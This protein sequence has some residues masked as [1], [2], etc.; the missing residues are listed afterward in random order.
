MNILY[1]N[2]ELATNDGSNYHALGILNNLQKQLGTDCVRCYPDPL[3][4]SKQ[5]VNHSSIKRREKYKLALQL[6]RIIRKTILSYT[7]YR[8]ICQKL[9]AENWKPTHVLARSVI[10]DTTAIRVA[11]YFRAK[12]IFEVNAPLYYEQCIINKLPL[13]HA[14]KHWEHTILKKADLIY[15]VSDICR[16]MLLE[17]YPDVK[18]DFVVIPNGYMDELYSM[19][20]TKKNKIRNTIR[21]KENLDSKFVITFIGSLKKW[22]GISFLCELASY[23]ESNPAYHFLVIGDG[24]ER[25]TVVEH[26]KKHNNMTY[27]GKLDSIQM[28][29]Y[30]LA[31]DLGIM[32]YEKNNKFYFSPLKMYDMIGS[33]LP[34]IGTD[35][36]Q[37]HDIAVTYLN[38][39]FLIENFSITNIYNQIIDISTDNTKYQ[40]MQTLLT[41][42]CK[43]SSWNYRAIQL[44]SAL[45]QLS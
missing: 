4:G 19:P 40:N 20:N 43:K 24:S 17:Q 23:F 13:A 27:V 11:R 10:F 32:P 22:H 3:D 12:L 18:T 38:K 9:K 31:S 25:N 6:I 28:A 45:K 30:L 1:I 14:V 8:S 35:Q 5:K 41:D 29:E 16:D 7:R 15:S 44:I 36:G 26:C 2:D 33:S 42:A 37:I 34:F 21:S 39:D